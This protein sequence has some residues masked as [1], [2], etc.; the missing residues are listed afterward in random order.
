MKNLKES[1]DSLPAFM[2]S[3]CGNGNIILYDFYKKYLYMF[4][5]KEN[6]KVLFENLLEWSNVYRKIDI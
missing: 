6:I 3:R 4:K 2:L 5:K 1:C